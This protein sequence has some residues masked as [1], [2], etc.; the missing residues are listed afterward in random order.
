ME[1]ITTPM[2]YEWTLSRA[3]T[4]A[5][6]LLSG[7]THVTLLS[8][9]MKQDRAGILGKLRKVSGLSQ[10]PQVLSRLMKLK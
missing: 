5:Q 8:L 7:T 2:F 10:A 9:R 6:A 4:V 1:K 3:I